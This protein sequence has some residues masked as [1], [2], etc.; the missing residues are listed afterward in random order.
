M[1]RR[2][3]LLLVAVVLVGLGLGCINYTKESTREHHVEWA[4][5]HNLPPPSQ[6]IFIGGLASTA[7]GAAVLLVGLIPRRGGGD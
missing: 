5:S 1:I 7:I 3:I 2:L 4:R 6:G